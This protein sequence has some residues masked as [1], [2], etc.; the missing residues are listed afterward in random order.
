MSS[1]VYE[2]VKKEIKMFNF[3]SGQSWMNEEKIIKV[4]GKKF[5]NQDL[6]EV[7]M[8]RFVVEEYKIIAY[9]LEN[10]KRIICDITEYDTLENVREDFIAIAGCHL[11]NVFYDDQKRPRLELYL[12]EIHKESGLLDFIFALLQSGVESCLKNKI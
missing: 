11:W 7:L 6:Y 9:D 2:Y 4:L 12:D 1:K 5:T 3:Q 10:R 8:W